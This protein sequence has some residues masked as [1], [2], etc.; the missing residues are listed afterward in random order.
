MPILLGWFLVA[1]FI[2]FAENIATYTNIWIYPNQATQWH[3]VPI[4]K[5]SSWFLLM[6]LSFVLVSLINNVV[7]PNAN[8]NVN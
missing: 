2:W 7:P 3:M 8:K 5:L 1:L 6:L 4:E